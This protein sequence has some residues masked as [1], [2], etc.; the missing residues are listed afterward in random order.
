[1]CQHVNESL[2][3]VSWDPK[4]Y[5]E[6]LHHITVTVV[7]KSNRRNEVTQLF[8]LDEKQTVYSDMLAQF[9]LHKHI[10]TIFRSLFWSSVFLCVTPLI[11]FR[12]WHELIKGEMI[13]SYKFKI[14]KSSI[15][16]P[17]FPFDC[18][19][20]IA[21]NARQMS[22][23]NVYRSALL[24]FGVSG[25]NILA[26]GFVL[27]LFVCGPSDV[28]WNRSRPIRFRFR[29]WNLCGRC[30][31]ARIIYF[32]V[33]ICTTA[34]VSIPFDLGVCNVCR[35][36]ILQNDRDAREE[37]SK[38]VEEIL[39]DS[40]LFRHYIGSISLHFVLLF[41]WRDWIYHGYISNVV[42]S[43]ARVTLLH[44]SECSRAFVKVIK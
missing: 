20:P 14:S 36:T 30:I 8:R 25:S 32:L 2:F 23:I 3:V 43:H 7:D 39:T 16:L 9:V 1:M 38:M 27:F 37:P 18:S 17:L 19:W 28:L 21:P 4:N 44:S 40:L 11:F 42:D 13:Y 31:F 12:I 5:R 26:C 35:E 10:V 34:A 29:V 6:G 24:D 22:C 41:I 15:V 33:R